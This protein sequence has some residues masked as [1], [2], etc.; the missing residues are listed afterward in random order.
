MR[1]KTIFM[2]FLS[3]VL[4]G[5]TTGAL[6]FVAGG[7]YYTPFIGAILS[8][9]EDTVGEIFA[10]VLT[11]IVLFFLYFFLF[12]R[13]TTRYLTEIAEALNKIADGD[14]DINIPIK[15]ND[16]LGFLA[17]NINNMAAK[18]K[19][20]IEDER[21]AER[22]K[23]ELITS[24]SHDLR[25]PLTSIM[26]YL[27][28]ITSDRYDDEIRMRHYADIAYQK[29][30][31]LKRMIDDL[32]ELTTLDHGKI[33]LNKARIDLGQ[34]LEQL[35]EEFVPILYEANMEYRLFL[36]NYKI[37]LEADAHMLVRVFENLI[38]NAIRYGEQGRYVDISMQ[39]EEAVAIV[40]IANYGNPIP[41]YE[42]KYIFDRF[43]RMEQSRSSE[44]GGTGLG[45]AI[46]KNI[47][48]LHGG[49][50]RA[51]TEGNKTIFEVKLIRG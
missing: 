27:E 12:T 49:Q 9:V 29:S 15:S 23:N 47:V 21:N 34:L 51:Y 19:K 42:L 6:L 16:E 17:Q 24:V 1:W 43:Y 2:F 5:V 46:A 40:S 36:P 13:K 45:L 28:L 38:S 14:L 44:T 32:F 10:M 35:T 41:E 7:L 20:S 4:A 25:T 33:E 26:G 37:E 18:L 3:I 39:G 31:R 48:E 11:A 50:I 22:T 8:I 30:K